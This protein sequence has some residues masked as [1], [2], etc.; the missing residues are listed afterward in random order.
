MNQLFTLRSLVFVAV[1]GLFALAGGSR[2]NGDDKKSSEEKKPEPVTVPFE[3][4]KTGHMAVMI[5]VNDKGPYRVIFDTGAPIS[6]LSTKVAKE[7][8]IKTE[9]KGLA[10]LLGVGGQAK[11]KTLEVGDAKLDNASLIVMDHPTI[12]AISKEVGALEGIIGFPVFARFKTTLNYRDKTLTLVPNGFEPPDVMESMQS[13]LTEMLTAPK[14]SGSA[15]PKQILSPSAQWGM[16]VTKKE[17]DE[18]PGVTVKEVF[19]GGA[20]EAA[21]LKSGDRILTLDSRW[22]DSVADTYLAAGFVKPGEAV[23]L[24]TKR[25]GKEKELTVKPKKGL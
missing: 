21:G 2:L 16:I 8:G 10:A 4:L 14:G 1:L 9:A 24:V 11:A 18:D 25:D 23:K 19:P 3:M 6:L 22:T 13:A 20:A 12:E 7:A 15:A 5:K 17:K